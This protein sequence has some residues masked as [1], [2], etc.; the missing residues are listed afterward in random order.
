MVARPP[1]PPFT[2]NTAIQKI[3]LAEDSWNTHDPD[4]VA[5]AGPM[6]SEI[7]LQSTGRSTR[8]ANCGLLHPA[9]Q[10]QAGHAPA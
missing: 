5:Q 3:R 2:R 6:D 10:D 9:G 1:L 8:W 7:I 4:K